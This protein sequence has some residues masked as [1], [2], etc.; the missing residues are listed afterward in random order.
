MR[1]SVAMVV[2]HVRCMGMSVPEPAVLVFVRVWF[3]RWVARLVCVP[4]V[5]VMHMAVG[6]D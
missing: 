3:A 6:M 5:P 4:M 1:A 2:M